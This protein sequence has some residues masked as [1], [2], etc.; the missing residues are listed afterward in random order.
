MKR[1]IFLLLGSIITGIVCFLAMHYVLSLNVKQAFSLSLTI[2]LTG[3][4][5]ELLKPYF[6]KAKN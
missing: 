6:V 4:I 2:A 5:V 1:L 3:L